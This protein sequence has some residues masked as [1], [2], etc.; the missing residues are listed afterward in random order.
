[1]YEI[2]H[3]VCYFTWIVEPV[4]YENRWGSLTFFSIIHQIVSWNGLSLSICAIQLYKLLV[5]KYSIWWLLS[6]DMVCSL[7]TKVGANLVFNIQTLISGFAPGSVFKT[8]NFLELW[9]TWQIVLPAWAPA[10]NGEN[11]MLHT[12]MTTLYAPLIRDERIN[13]F[14]V[15]L[16]GAVLY[17]D[18]DHLKLLNKSILIFL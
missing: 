12:R 2:V 15:L 7:I 3:V 11:I 14:Y 1:M 8:E 17:N 10:K 4:W 6:F 18:L 13:K 5:V 16:S 9:W